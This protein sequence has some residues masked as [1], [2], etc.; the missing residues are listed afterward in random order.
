MCVEF[1]LYVLFYMTNI[2]HVTVLDERRT[3]GIQEVRNINYFNSKAQQ[4]IHTVVMI[5]FSVDVQ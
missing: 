5:T 3:E 1:E 4:N 2:S